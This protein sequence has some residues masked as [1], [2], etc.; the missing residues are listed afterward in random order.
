MRRDKVL[1]MGMDEGE[2]F[3]FCSALT[4]VVQMT[5]WMLEVA[6]WESCVNVDVRVLRGFRSKVIEITTFS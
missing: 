2:L 5:P 4:F 6:L 3:G 1:V